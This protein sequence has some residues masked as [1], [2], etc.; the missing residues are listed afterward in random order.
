MLHINKRLTIRY[1]F[2]TESVADSK[3]DIFVY[4]KKDKQ[5]LCYLRIE[6]RSIHNNWSPDYKIHPLKVDRSCVSENDFP[7]YHAGYL[8]ARFTMFSGSPRLEKWLPPSKSDAKKPLR[9]IVNLIRGIDLPSGDDDGLSDPF[10]EVEHYGN[11]KISTVCNKT[12]D[13]VWNQRLIL[14]SYCIEDRI[15]PLVTNVFDS[16]SDDPRKQKFEFLGRAVIP[17]PETLTSEDKVNVVP[18]L[19]WYQLE[20][21]ANLKMGKIMLSIQ[22]MP[23]TFRIERLLPMAYNKSKYLMKFKLLG[24]RKYSSSG[25]FPIKKPYIKINLSAC[26]GESATSSE[27]DLLTANSK[28]GNSEANFSEIIK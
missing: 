25:I 7:D 15:M 8:R 11:T 19:D 16:D 6:G 9:I 20:N 21:S 14:D 26:K 28:S 4:L 2:T 5:T 10:V 3:P 12:L 13:P 22:V 27:L 1:D 24:L 23:T 17:L 18:K